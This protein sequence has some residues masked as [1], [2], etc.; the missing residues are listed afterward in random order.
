MKLCQGQTYKRGEAFLRITKLERLE[1]DY[2]I[3]ENLTTKEGAHH[4]S[5]KKEFCRM[6]KDW[7]LMTKEEVAAERV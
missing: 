7:V 5:S 2:K 6:I 3:M 1:V 4:H